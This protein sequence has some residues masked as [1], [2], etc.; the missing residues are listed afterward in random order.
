MNVK[1]NSNQENQYRAN[2]D[3]SFGGTV[4]GFNQYE[5]IDESNM[6]HYDYP[7]EGDIEMIVNTRNFCLNNQPSAILPSL[8]TLEDDTGLSVNTK[9]NR[10]CN[11]GKKRSKDTEPH[12]GFSNTLETKIFRNN[13]A[14][15]DSERMSTASSQGNT[16]TMQ[17][18]IHT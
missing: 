3:L 10:T 11:H 7:T 18:G 8:S 12:G 1:R 15:Y 9:L 4:D 13:T 14:S 16:N 2:E 6:R 5:S 17:K